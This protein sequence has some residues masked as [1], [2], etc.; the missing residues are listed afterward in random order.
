MELIKDI[1]FNF[2]VDHQCHWS[3][4]GVAARRELYHS[5]TCIY[6]LGRTGIASG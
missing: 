6:L 3:Q 4:G 1:A 2:D 5:V